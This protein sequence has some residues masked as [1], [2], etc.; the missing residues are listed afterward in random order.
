MSASICYR[1]GH[2]DHRGSVP[3]ETWFGSRVAVRKEN[4]GGM[5]V[6]EV[7][8]YERLLG[9]SWGSLP[10]VLQRAH[11]RDAQII[12]IGEMDVTLGRFRGA[13]LIRWALR[14]PP[15]E[16]RMPVEL[17][18]TRTGQREH[19]QSGQREHWDRRIGPWRLRTEQWAEDGLM[20][21]RYGPLLFLMAVSS[22]DDALTLSS[23]KMM[24]S[25]RG[26]RWPVPRRLSL[27]TSAVEQQ[28][29]GRH[30]EMNVTVRI[31]MPSGQLLV[32]YHGTLKA[33]SEAGAQQQ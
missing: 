24:L 16:G 4:R 21:E 1:S 20:A 13:G 26:C 9:E 30:D 7:G 5:A 11:G 31:E 32:G 27:R 8:L 25:V 2:G 33:T 18:V 14:M 23:G 29:A 28:A 17:R 19:S 6:D 12:S 15:T 22:V 10:D 3:P